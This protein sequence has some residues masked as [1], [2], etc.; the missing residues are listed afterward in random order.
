MFV[1]LRDPCV[2]R[3]GCVGDVLV[4]FGD[5]AAMFARCC[6]DAL[7]TAWRCVGD[8]LGAVSYAF[9]IFWRGLGVV[10]GI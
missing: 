10:L 6:G 7:R 3:W 4:L 1:M 8:V 2:M 9:M 5:V